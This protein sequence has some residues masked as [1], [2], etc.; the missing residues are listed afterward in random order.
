MYKSICGNKYFI[1]SLIAVLGLLAYSNS[2]TVPFQFDDEAYVVSNPIIRTFHYFLA[3]FDIAKLENLSPTSLPPALQFAFMTRML[4]YF[5][6]AVNFKLHGLNVVG[7]HVVNLTL[8]LMSGYLV[9]LIARGTLGLERCAPRGGDESRAGY[10]GAI[11]AA[12]ALLFVVHPIQT[13][14]VTYITSRFLLMA[15]FFYLLALLSY[16]KSQTETAGRQ[17]LWY[18]LA[19][20]STVCS[21]LSKEFSFTLPFV[22]ALYDF[23]FLD[24][25]RRRRLKALAPFA[26]TVC[27]IPILVFL[28]QGQ[29]GALDSTMRTIT[30]ADVSKISRGDYLLTQFG[31][32]TDYLRLLL[33]PIHQN[34]DH[35]FTKYHSFFAWPV[36]G[37]F[38]LLL[39]LFLFGGYCYY[40]CGRRR[41]YPE[42]RLAGFGILWFFVTLSVESSILPLGELGAEYRVYLPSFGFFLAVTAL[43]HLAVRARLGS[44]TGL[45]LYTGLLGVTIVVL[46]VAT[47]SRNMVWQNEISL[48]EDSAKLSPNKLRP[49]QNLGL[50]YSTAGRLNEAKRE[51]IAALKIEPNNFELHNNLGI[52]YKKLGDYQNAIS[53]YTRASQLNPS[54]PMSLYNLANAYLAQGDFA[55]AIRY[56]EKCLQIIPDYDELHNNLAIA[57]QKTGRHGDA[58][59]EYETAVKL[60]PENSHARRNLENIRKMTGDTGKN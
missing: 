23:T 24:S 16:L 46:A 55:A 12:A 21:M 26:V 53:A 45:R 36:F 18:G 51:L 42:L 27:I 19:L 29:L 56:Y 58:I 44:A 9:Y 48:W 57:Y 54:D 30:A 14:A 52:V 60:N 38:L 13:H 33:L 4:G 1:A 3:P 2:F 17:G 40:L 39:A 31:V 8:H 47:Y 11:A 43:V 35:D 59:R 5:T 37:Y 15:S 25:D 20:A 22:I 41:E 6:L 34:V 32:I 10:P 28:Q 50:Y 49:H 7:Y